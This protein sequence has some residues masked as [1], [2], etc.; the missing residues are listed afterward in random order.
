MDEMKKKRIAVVGIGG[1]GG[2]LAAM[3][4]TTY[5][6]QLTLVARGER[7]Q[8]LREQGL[9]M[10]SERDGEKHIRPQNVVE[11]EHLQEQDVIFLCV[12]NYSLEQTCEQIS[13]AV[14][15]HT[16]VIPVMNGVDSAERV[17]GVLKKGIVADAV[18]YIVAFIGEDGNICQQGDFAQIFF[19]MNG[20]KEEQ[21]VHLQEVLQ[22][23][24]QADIDAT[25]AEDIEME[26]WR[27]YIL[28]CAYNV[29]TAAY[30]HTIGQLRSDEGK[31]REFEALI[32][33]AYGIAKKKGVA[34]TDAMIE[35]FIYRFYH[36]YRDDA[37]S[38]LQRDIN[39]GKQAEIE[40]FSGYVVRES[41]KYELDAPVSKK[42]YDLL[43]ARTK[44]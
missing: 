38:S 1:V 33:E 16:I 44:K 6:E 32:T 17:R 27:K 29:E 9:R 39:A 21:K 41:E 15:E 23:L 2:Y 26:V 25:L 5:S 8:R 35:D 37:T 43:E 19:G 20:A 12:K 11:A 28:N 40:T 31:A 24:K 10:D 13:H 7:M 22:I 34:V 42:M 30:N 36:V 3:L 14:G 18:I 4:G